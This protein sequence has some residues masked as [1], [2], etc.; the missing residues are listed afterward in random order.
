MIG[1][2]GWAGLSM[3]PEARSREWE[4]FCCKGAGLMNDRVGECQKFAVALSP[5][6]RGLPN[7][8]S[9]SVQMDVLLLRRPT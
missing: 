6:M 2:L 4:E 1:V 9:R 7:R 5:H 8:P 3:A